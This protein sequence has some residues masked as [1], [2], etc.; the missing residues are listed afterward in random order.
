MRGIFTPAA[1]TTTGRVYRDRVWI[2]VDLV[3]TVGLLVTA[4]MFQLVWLWLLGFAWLGLAARQAR[5][6]QRSSR[7]AAGR[8]GQS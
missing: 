5:L 4:V 3:A 7:A 8:P 1:L 6:A 2:A